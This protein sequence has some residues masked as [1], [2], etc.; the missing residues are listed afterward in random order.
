MVGLG[1]L[2][3]PGSPVVPSPSRSLSSGTFQKGQ[4]GGFTEV[5]EDSL[6]DSLELLS[7][8]YLPSAARALF[9]DVH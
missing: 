1:S 2:G 5:G 6:L 9:A 3:S 8:T 4:E 7:Y